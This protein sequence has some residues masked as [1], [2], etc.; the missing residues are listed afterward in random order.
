VNVAYKHLDAKLRISEFTVGQWFIMIASTLV[1]IAY[2]R[3]V[4][5]FGA[6]LTLATAVYVGGLPIAIVIVANFSEFDFGLLV[7][8][9]VRWRRLDARYMPGPGA[10][11][12]GYRLIEPPE[13]SRR[14]ERERV[15]QLDLVSLWGER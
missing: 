15:A 11:T 2:G 5:P 8:C 1:A 12:D 14:A 10:R 13:E 4:S 6:G 3:Y 7:R 9:A